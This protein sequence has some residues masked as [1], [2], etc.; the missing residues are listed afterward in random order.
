MCTTVPRLAANISMLFGEWPFPERFG[1]AAAAG[2]DAVECQFPY[3]WPVDLLA[4]G[5]AASGLTLVL[6]NAPPGDLAG[7]DRGLAAVEGRD[8]EFRASIEIALAYAETLGCP[9]VHVMAG[10]SYPSTATATSRYVDRLGWAAD[11]L[12]SAGITVQIEPLNDRDFPGYLLRGTRQA[13]AVIAAVGRPNVFL[14]FDTYHLQILEGDLIT[15]FRRCREIIG[16]VQIA[17]VPDRGEPDRGEV[18]HRWLLNELDAADW[19]GWIGAEYR[20]RGHTLAGLDWARPYGVDRR[21]E[22]DDQ[23]EHAGT[24]LGGDANR[25]GR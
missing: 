1:A 23:G 11:R 18:D 6:L 2:F 14:Q 7:G 19:D 16:H 10:A 12:G 20:P 25:R 5:L 21:S 9:R 24:P 3:E 15:S 8:E 22:P 17:A 13:E 4:A